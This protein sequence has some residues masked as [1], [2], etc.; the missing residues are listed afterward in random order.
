[1]LERDSAGEP[2]SAPV[3]TLLVSPD[4]AQKLTLATSQGHIQ[5]ALRNPLDTRQ[6]EL[7]AVKTG[8]LYKY[9]P[10]PAAPAAPK[11]K[12][13]KVATAPMAATPYTIEIIRGD[14]KDE[15]KF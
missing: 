8:T 14:K 15:T 5:L 3:V 6:Q 13:K 11:V 9:A 7:A 10:P 4:D 2:Q 1:R 12:A